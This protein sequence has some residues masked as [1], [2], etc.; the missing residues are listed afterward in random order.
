MSHKKHDRPRDDGTPMPPHPP[1]APAP[2]PPPE[3]PRHD[4]PPPERPP[5]PEP[6][7]DLPPQRVMCPASGLVMF[8]GCRVGVYISGEDTE[9]FAALTH[10]ASLKALLIEANSPRIDWNQV[11]R[12]RPWAEIVK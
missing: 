5:A 3:P 12:L 2:P 8:D 7:P 1:H 9:A 6:P 10:N 11:V 4:P